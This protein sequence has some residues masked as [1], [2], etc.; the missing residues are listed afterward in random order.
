MLMHFFVSVVKVF[1]DNL[2]D[3]IELSTL[4]ATGSWSGRSMAHK[5]ECHFERNISSI[6]PR[7]KFVVLC[8]SFVG[9]L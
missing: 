8:I 5:G 9:L 3:W 7:Q 4:L 2:S 1:S 6:Y